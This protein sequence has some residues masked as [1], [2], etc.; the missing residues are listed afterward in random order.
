MYKPFVKWSIVF[1]LL[2]NVFFHLNIYNGEYG[3]RGNVSYL[4]EFKDYAIGAVHILTSMSDTAQ[5]LG[6][7]WFLKSLFVGSIFGYV[8]IK[9]VK[10]PVYGGGILLCLT[11]GLA[12]L[13]INVPYFGIGAKEFFAAEFFVLGF[14]YKKYKISIHKYVIIVPFGIVIIT[15]GVHYYQATLLRFLWWQVVPYM[16][17]ATVGLL[18]VFYVS[19][20]IEKCHNKGCA[21]LVYIGNN[22]LTILTW[23]ML[24]FKIVSLLIIL[25]YEL[26]IA[27]MAEFPVIEEYSKQ[28]WFFLY[29]I[30]GVLVPLWMTKSK[31]L[32]QNG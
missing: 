22:T 26:P 4:Y 21:L 17:T 13:Q 2:H 5:L 32:K 18:A 30:V 12:Y 1:L 20:I 14:Y 19:K 25:I 27:R 24:S 15:F 23:H 28:G 31:Y 8:I 10:S 29:F 3:F 6:G 7:Y 11:L 9:Y 16:L